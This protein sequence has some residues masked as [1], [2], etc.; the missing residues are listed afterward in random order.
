MSPLSEDR[1]AAIRE[2][3]NSEQAISTEDA[4]FLLRSNDR[5]RSMLAHRVHEVERLKVE[6]KRLRG[7]LRE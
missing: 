6:V 3:L 1:I 2:Q 5:L 4:Q 7:Q